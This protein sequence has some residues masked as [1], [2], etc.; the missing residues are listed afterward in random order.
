MESPTTATVEEEVNEAQLAA[1]TIADAQ[2]NATLAAEAAERE[3]AERAFYKAEDQQPITITID[4]EKV[5]EFRNEL[6]RIGEPHI[7]TEEVREY[8]KSLI[9]S[10][11][12]YR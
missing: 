12:S 9:I 8:M 6:K 11:I 10:W 2:Y 7:N 4:A 5:A 3:A 1:I